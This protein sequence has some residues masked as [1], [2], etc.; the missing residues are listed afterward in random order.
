MLR[1]GR[2]AF[3]REMTRGSYAIEGVKVGLAG[4]VAAAA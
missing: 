1:P 2:S 3:A 4:A